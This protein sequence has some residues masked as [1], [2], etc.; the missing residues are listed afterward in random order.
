M[1]ILIYS[2]PQQPQNTL[3]ALQI[4]L[5]QLTSNQPPG[6]PEQSVVYQQMDEQTQQTYV[7]PSQDPTEAS[8]IQYV[9]TYEI[10]FQVPIC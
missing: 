9:I 10:I 8:Q 2:V 1:S 7:L 4:K 5:A 3:A 6:Q